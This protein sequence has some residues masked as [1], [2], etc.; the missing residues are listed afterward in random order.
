MKDKCKKLCEHPSTVFIPMGVIREGS[1]RIFTQQ[2]YVELSWAETCKRRGIRKNF[3]HTEV[4]SLKD[5]REVESIPRGDGT[6]DSY[7]SK[8]MTLFVH[9]LGG[10]TRGTHWKWG[11]V[12]CMEQIRNH[13]A[14]TKMVAEKWKG[15]A[16]RESRSNLLHLKL[17]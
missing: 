7:L 13:E 10:D 15:E 12:C 6:K 4:C 14:W 17:T 8:E 1:W 16:F 9:M 2:A 5:G 11:R 3:K